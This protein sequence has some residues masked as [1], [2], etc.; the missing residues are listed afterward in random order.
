MI[1]LVINMLMPV[2][3]NSVTHLRALL[4]LHGRG[5][6]AHVTSVTGRFL[7]TYGRGDHFPL[8]PSMASFAIDHPS[9]GHLLLPKGTHWIPDPKLNS[10][11]LLPLWIPRSGILLPTQRV[12]SSVWH[13]IGLF[14]IESKHHGDAEEALVLKGRGGASV[15]IQ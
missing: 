7:F 6:L 2:K 4:V 1:I 5:I 9:Y 10:L 14:V 13:P 11:L 15:N 8:P 3:L 12:Y